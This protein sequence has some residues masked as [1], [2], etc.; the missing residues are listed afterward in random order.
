MKRL[1]IQFKT[2]IKLGIV[3]EYIALLKYDFETYIKKNILSV[4]LHRFAFSPV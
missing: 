2:A 3:F 1:F 4:S